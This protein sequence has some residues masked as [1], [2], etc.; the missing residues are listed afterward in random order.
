MP[1][2]RVTRRGSIGQCS[3]KVGGCRKRG[4]ACRQCKC[5]CDGVAPLDALCRKI[6]KVA[7]K[8]TRKPRLQKNSTRKRRQC[9][10]KVVGGGIR[11]LNENNITN[12]K[13][14]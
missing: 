2:I 3:C 13:Q 12:N 8:T 4:S 11:M 5:A 9:P 7:K 1:I 10:K 14:R 6:G